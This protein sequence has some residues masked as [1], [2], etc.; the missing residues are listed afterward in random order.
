MCLECFTIEKCPKKSNCLPINYLAISASTGVGIGFSQM[1]EFLGVLDIPSMGSSTYNRVQKDVQQDISDACNAEMYSAAMEAKTLATERGDVD[2]DGVPLLSVV[3]DACFSKRTYGIGSSYSSLSAAGTIIALDTGKVIWS[4]VANKY[5]RICS[6]H[7]KNK[8][9]EEFVPP[10]ECN[11]NFVGPS[12]AM[13]A[14]LI[15]EGFKQSENFY[16]VRYNRIVADGD[17]SVYKKLLDAKPYPNLHIEKI[18]CRNHL[19]R[20]M[21]KK[22]RELIGNSK[23]LLRDRLKVKRNATRIIVDI[24]C[25]IKHRK[26]MEV[27]F[28]DKV[29]LL[30]KDFDNVLNHVFGS[31]D[32]CEPYYCSGSKEGEINEMTALKNTETISNLR[33]I[34][35]RLREH[36]KSLIYYLE[37]RS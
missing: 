7:E 1:E 9:Q 30:K 14:H 36:A 17:S 12:T 19:M 22:I 37:L 4:S 35:N 3:T 5:C 29:S 33:S 27:N 28:N 20:N 2:K 15:V 26:N 11:R 25:A 6:H 23:L 10:H 31:H 21:R 13:E 34:I 18:E 16:G 32:Q 8:S 24:F